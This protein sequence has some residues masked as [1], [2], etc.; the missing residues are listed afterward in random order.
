[1][2]S[3][4]IRIKAFGGSHHTQIEARV[5]EWLDENDVEVVDIKFQIASSDKWSL[6]EEAYIIY[7]I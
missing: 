2:N 6:K 7:K 3:K 5:N 1:M 4:T